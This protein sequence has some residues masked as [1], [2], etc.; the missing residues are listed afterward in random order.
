MCICIYGALRLHGLYRRSLPV[1]CFHAVGE[2][3]SSLG[4]DGQWS[5]PVE[6]PLQLRV[7]RVDTYAKHRPYT[8]CRSYIRR[9][10][11]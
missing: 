6:M 5:V 3:L 2:M 9:L 7:C 4:V 1:C 10:Y 8:K 11:S